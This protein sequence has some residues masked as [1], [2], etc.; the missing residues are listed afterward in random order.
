[1]A[2]EQASSLSVVEW[3]NLVTLQVPGLRHYQ[4]L[5]VLAAEEVGKDNLQ[6]QED[7]P[8]QMALQVKEIKVVMVR[9]VLLVVMVPAAAVEQEL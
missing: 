2:Q 4:Q 9:Q 5:V 7:L 3:A 1:L 8:E 6:Q